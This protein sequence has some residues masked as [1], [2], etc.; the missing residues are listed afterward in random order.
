MRALNFV[1]LQLFFL[2]GSSSFVWGD[3]PVNFPIHAGRTGKF[4]VA[5][6]FQDNMVIQQGKP[7]RLWGWASPG[8]SIRMTADWQHD[9]ISVVTDRDGSWTGQIDVPAAGQGDFSAHTM[10]VFNQTDTTGFSNV[11]IGEV[12]ICA[13]QS[14]MDMRLQ[15]IEGWYGGVVDY[16]SEIE[17]ADYPA[18]RL[19]TEAISFNIEPQ[20][21][22]NG[23]WKVCSPQ[24]AGNFSAVSYFFGRE[25]FRKLNI[26]IGLVVVAAAGAGGQAFAPRN[27]LLEDSLL[28]KL[29]WEPYKADIQSQDK[30]DSMNFFTKV[31]NPSLIYNGMIHPIEK[32]SVSGFIWYQGESNYRDKENYTRLCGNMLDSWRL[33][34]NQ[35][36]LPFYFVQIAPYANN[37]DTCKSILPS[38]W[39]AQQRLLKKVNVGMALSQDA[40]ELKNIHPSNKKPIGTRLAKLALHRTYGFKNMVD[41]GP[42]VSAVRIK[43]NGIVRLSF[44]PETIGSGLD[45][46]DGKAPGFFLLAGS[47]SVFYP[48]VSRIIRNKVV[49]W[50]E[51]VPRPVAIRYGFTNDAIT[52]FQNKERL[53]AFP[54]R[55]D[56]WPLCSLP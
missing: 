55:S 48:A 2:F 15:K 52:N 29:Y 1:F 49:L 47:D 17:N 18:I 4:Q 50:S 16:Q 3:A 10:K 35:G 56:N 51:S 13:G 22:C 14:N 53:P 39:E 45:T 34:F 19:Y 31:R 37:S 36:A 54:Y 30:V 23:K 21:D 24:T 11:L 6:I 28:K 33:N 44:S 46:R 40:G 5:G 32:L 9:T 43:R 25:L 27:V 42:M 12:W 26:P 41:Q 20:Q 7:F 8:D 38:F